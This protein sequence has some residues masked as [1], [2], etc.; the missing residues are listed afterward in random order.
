MHREHRGVVVA[1]ALEGRASS[2]RYVRLT[3]PNVMNAASPSVSYRTHARAVH[4]WT[5]RLARSSLPLFALSEEE[6][7]KPGQ[8]IV[9]LSAEISDCVGSA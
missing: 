4:D 3:D 8:K 2:N 6:K 5:T 9:Y 7:P 1:S